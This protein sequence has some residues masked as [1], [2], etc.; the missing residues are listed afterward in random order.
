MV[1]GLLA[2]AETV[3]IIPKMRRPYNTAFTINANDIAHPW[4]GSP[5]GDG[6]SIGDRERS[7]LSQ[8]TRVFHMAG[9]GTGAMVNR[10]EDEA[11]GY[12]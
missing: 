9:A 6:R 11:G 2:N 3:V 1:L 5:G 7:C 4:S 10:S 12:Q 8:G